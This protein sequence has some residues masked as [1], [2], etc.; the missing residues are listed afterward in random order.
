M[1][2]WVSVKGQGGP[3]VPVVHQLMSNDVLRDAAVVP[4][5]EWRRDRGLLFPMEG[6]W[7]G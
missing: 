4:F 5:R 6:I 7:A 2:C 1:R 3:G